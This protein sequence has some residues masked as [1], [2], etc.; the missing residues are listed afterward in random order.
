M[1]SV[2]KNTGQAIMILF[3]LFLRNIFWFLHLS[4][5]K[6]P[7]FSISLLFRVLKGTEHSHCASK[8]AWRKKA[9]ID[10]SSVESTLEKV[11][12]SLK[13]LDGLFVFENKLEPVISFRMQK[14]FHGAF[15][16]FQLH[17]HFCRGSVW[18]YGIFHSMN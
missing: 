8:V 14:Q 3:L 1:N 9:V 6:R 5:S 13:Y 11:Y 4:A 18:N 17:K 16:L 15:A 12:C 10:E 7:I 2:E